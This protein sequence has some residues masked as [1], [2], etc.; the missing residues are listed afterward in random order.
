M[1]LSVTITA[2]S[3]AALH[4]ELLSTAAFFAPP[5]SQQGEV[6]VPAPAPEPKK[7]GPKPK[8]DAP[9]EPV[10]TDI[11]EAAKEVTHDDVVAALSKV[12]G[13]RGMQTVRDILGKFGVD[14]IS[15]IKPEDRAAV[16]AAAKAIIE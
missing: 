11:E 12:N 16:V 8:A 13:D 7:R 14:K 1:T 4:T 6:L 9:K 10:Q 15:Q 2:D 3:P 5:V